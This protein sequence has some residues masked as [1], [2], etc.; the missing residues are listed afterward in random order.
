MKFKEFLSVLD[1]V[2]QVDLLESNF[3]LELSTSRVSACY[4]PM[5]KIGSPSEFPIESS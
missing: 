1:R 5:R 3:S 2:L 4:S